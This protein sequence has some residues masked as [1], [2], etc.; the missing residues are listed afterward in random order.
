MTEQA[1]EFARW[2]LE[3]SFDGCDIDGCDAQE[4][5]HELGLVKKEA[6]DFKLHHNIINSDMC[7]PGDEVYLFTELIEKEQ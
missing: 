7:E 6:F 3:Q 2:I 5:A 4:K 1:N